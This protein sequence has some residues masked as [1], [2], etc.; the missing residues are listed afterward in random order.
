MTTITVQ[1]LGYYEEWNLKPWSGICGTS[2][3]STRN[4]L[5]FLEI[6]VGSIINKELDQLPDR[7]N[8]RL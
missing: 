2:P 3:Q 5:P 7:Q 6:Q 1:L 8:M 4:F